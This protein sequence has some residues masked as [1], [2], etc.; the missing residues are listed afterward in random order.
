VEAIHETMI[1]PLLVR[2]RAASVLVASSVMVTGL[3]PPAAGRRRIA[4]GRRG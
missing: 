4:A 2:G 1:R 3:L